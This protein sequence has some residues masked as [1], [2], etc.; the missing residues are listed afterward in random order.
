MFRTA[1]LTKRSLH[2]LKRAA[3]AIGDDVSSEAKDRLKDAIGAVGEAYDHT[4]EK[5]LGAAGAADG[6]VRHKA[7]LLMGIA[8]GTALAAG[9][10]LRGGGH[11]SHS[12]A[13]PELP[14]MDA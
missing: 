11:K 12:P 2:R 6:F 9:C 8:A 10:A 7:L 13:T 3:R 4:R 14:V 1:T 5:A